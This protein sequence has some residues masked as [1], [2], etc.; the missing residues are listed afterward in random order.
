MQSFYG[1]AC[2]RVTNALI[3]QTAKRGSHRLF[4]SPLLMYALYLHKEV[5]G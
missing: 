2:H 4:D 1:T 5:Q 3:L